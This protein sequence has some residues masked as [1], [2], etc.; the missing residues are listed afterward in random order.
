MLR[1][2]GLKLEVANGIGKV[3]LGAYRTS[4]NKT[5]TETRTGT[6]VYGSVCTV[7][8]EDGSGGPGASYPILEL[9]GSGY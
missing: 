3:K 1:F 6:A 5:I 4:G 7:V 8:W 2:G 9:I